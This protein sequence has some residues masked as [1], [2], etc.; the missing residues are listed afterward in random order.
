MNLFQPQFIVSFPAPA[1]CLHLI[2]YSLA[3][4]CYTLMLQCPERN[5]NT[6]LN[7]DTLLQAVQLIFNTLS[8]SP[9]PQR[10]KIQKYM[11]YNPGSQAEAPWLC[12]SLSAVPGREGGDA[13]GTAML[14]TKGSP[15]YKPCFHDLPLLTRES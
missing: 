5:L 11:C 1:I 12:F 6:V 14:T 4:G 9:A 15:S 3:R 8:L 7:Y 10:Q 2:P 13:L